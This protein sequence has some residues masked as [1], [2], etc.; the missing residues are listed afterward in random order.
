MS[1]PLPIL[2]ENSI[3]IAWDYLEQSGEIDDA[4]LAGHFLLDHVELLI[5]QGERRRL[6][7]SNN[8]IT[9]YRNFKQE[10]RAA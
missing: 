6:L 10:R 1:E 2:I 8:A 3:Q 4:D 5:R 9:A 7:L